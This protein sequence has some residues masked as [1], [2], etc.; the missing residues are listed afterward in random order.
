MNFVADRVTVQMMG[1]YNRF[2]ER[3]YFKLCSNFH[4]TQAALLPHQKC[5]DGNADEAARG[6]TRSFPSTR[7]AIGGRGEHLIDDQMESGGCTPVED[8]HHAVSSGELGCREDQLSAVTSAK[9][10]LLIKAAI[11]SQHRHAVQLREFDGRDGG[12]ADT[13]Q[14]F[15]AHVLVELRC[16]ESQ[17]NATSLASLRRHSH[18]RPLRRL[19]EGDGRFDAVCRQRSVVGGAVKCSL[20]A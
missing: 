7:S 4:V 13:Y 20:P 15:D 10:P 18:V 5:G 17:L 12:A 8:G 19:D 16:S 1:V 6:Y 3:P 11:A 14:S 2:A 9:S